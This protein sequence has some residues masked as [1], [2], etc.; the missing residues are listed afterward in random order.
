VWKVLL[1]V[2]NIDVYY[3]DMHILRDVSLEVVKGEIVLV[4]GSNG[5]GKT[6][7]LRAV[8]GL[9][10]LRSG[11]IRFNDEAIDGLPPH[12]IAERGISH[13][14]EGRRVFPLMTVKENLELGAYMKQAAKKQKETMNSVFEI[15]PA[16]KERQNQPA[17]TL[18]GGEQQMLAIGRGLMSCPRLLLLDEPSSGL[19]P[20][21]V[22]RLFKL[23]AKEI[24]G[25]GV[26]ILLV[27][28]NIR[29]ALQIANRAYILENGGIVLE[30]E[31]QDLLNNQH[32]K[33]AYLGI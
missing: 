31:A 20:I 9:L 5:S 11:T 13:V 24:C 14:P 12:Q 32:V 15:L 22:Q 10:D 2:D 3:G 27:E 18:S 4:A 19:A 29:S 16:L 8:S 6:T 25:K 28:Q 17:G 30:G 26:T 33:K 7:L 1:E 23:I 21:I